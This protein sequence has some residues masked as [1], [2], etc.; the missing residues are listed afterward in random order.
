MAS[1]SAGG[2]R[3][4][5][6]TGTQSSKKRKTIP[7]GVQLEDFYAYMPMHSYLFAPTGDL[8]PASS[9]NARVSPVPLLDSKGQPRLSD[10]GNPEAIRASTWLDQNRA[11]E[12]MTWIPGE[13]MLIEDRLISGGGWI[14]RAGVRTFNLNRAPSIEPGDPAKAGPWLEHIRRVFPDYAEHLVHWLAHRVQRPGEKINHAIALIGPQ[15]TGKDTIIQGVIPAVG[16]WNVQEVG[17]DAL[18]GRFTGFVKSV[19][20]RVSEARDLGDTDRYRLYEHLK[21]F[22]AA[23][24]DVLRV[25]EKHLRE[26]AVPNVCGVVITSNHTDGI[27]LPA[28]DR[29]HYVAATELTK[30]D[31]EESYWTELYRWYEAGGYRHVAAYLHSLDLSGFNPKAP[32]PKTA[33]FW[34]VVDAGRAPEDAELADVLDKLMWP[35]AITVGELAEQAETT[36]GEWLRDRRNSRQVPHRMASVGYVATRNDAQADGRWKVGGKNQMIYAKRELSIR[37]RIAAAQTLSR[38]SR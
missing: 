1:P 35:Q 7:E 23:P 5:K 31:F 36:F 17:P 4:R 19:I 32:P 20:L 30:E 14:D 10:D 3:C 8:W 18:L 33:A 16:P 29:R 25:D 2:N 15:G 37:D 28:D 27:Y 26:Y 9:V 34:T 12:Q 38:A 21:V 6:K 13:P 11:V 22:T 24:P